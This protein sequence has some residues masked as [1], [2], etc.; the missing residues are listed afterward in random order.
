MATTLPRLTTTRRGALQLFGG[1][2]LALAMPLRP[3]RAQ[4]GAAFAPN[5]FVR[6][7][8][9][10]TVTVLIKHIEFG[11]GPWTGLA[12]LVAEEM[13]AAWPQIR[14]EAAPSNTDLYK[15]FLF[16]IQGTGG[17]TAIANSYEQMRKAGAAARAMLVA[18]AARTWGAPAGEI[19]VADGVVSHA[20]SGRSARFGELA[21][22]AAQETPPEDPAL[23]DRSAFK[24]IGKE[25]PKL[26]TA[27]KTDGSAE[28]TLDVYRENMLTSVVEHP[29]KF[30]ARVA[31][32]DAA[33]AREV[34]G[35][36]DVQETPFGVAVYAENTF[37]ALKG[38]K[39][40][41]VDW[42][43]GGAEKRSSAALA[44]MAMGLAQSPGV[45]VTV[46]EDDAI[47]GALETGTTLEADYLF[48]FLAHAP[49][50][51]LDAVLE[52]NGDA[53]E[54]WMGAQ[55]Q[56]GDHQ[57]IAGVL[58]TDPANVT[59]N[60]MLAGGS[61][62]RRAQPGS[63]FA[64]EAAAVFA[65]SG[66]SRAV[67]I[68]WTREDDV[69][70]GFYRPLTAPRLRGAIGAD[71]KLAAWEQ[72]IATQSLVRGSP[73]EGMITG[74]YDPTTVEGARD[75]YYGVGPIR[76]TVHEF[77][78]GVP[79][80]WWRSV[81]HTHTGY[82]I[83][84]FMDE[85]LDKAGRDAVDGRLAH[86]DEQPRVAG[87]LRRA[88]DL[89]DWGRRPRD[90]AAFGV[91]VHPSFGSFVAQIAEVSMED[92]PLGP[93]PRVHNVW[94]AVDCGQPVNVNVIQA[95]IEGGVGYGLGGV[96]L[97]ELT[98]DE[99]GAP[100][101]SN[102]H[103]YRSLRVDAMPNVEV[104]VIDSAEAPTGVG[105]PGVPPIGPAV[106]NAMRR[107]TGETPRRLPFLAA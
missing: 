50:E 7:G 36:V 44:E 16:G 97:N 59:L 3:A 57:T 24:F 39:A 82:A 92:G 9:D 22:A 80:L 51:P 37:A 89:A 55:L 58:E 77:E 86:L 30:G 87:V 70:G 96:L 91:A 29:P 81:G 102:F 99:G 63:Q 32:V 73:F 62:G 35:V 8:D 100:V 6:V 33:A 69:R 23:K 95:Q 52:Q 1:F 10:D 46:R 27:M 68:M 98:L 93:T 47:E 14:A 53:V 12:T 104:A 61:F 75:F 40:L 79:V 4:D 94:A 20:A 17:S 49:M 48:P 106:A 5:A 26:D 65:A 21:P 11:Q 43:D 45:A 56:T 19:T 67:K 25:L 88:A 85:L 90:G 76:V 18:A 71:G 34:P 42:D 84:T 15:N 54:V 107:L 101:Q 38:R 83:E 13:D 64:A 66:R 28:F 105:E 74:E 78:T 72:T 2:T 31:S 103:D 41:K 60:T